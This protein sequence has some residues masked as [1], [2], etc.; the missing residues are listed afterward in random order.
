MSTWLDAAVPYLSALNA[1]EATYGIPHNLLARIAWQESHFRSDIISGAMKSPA[2]AVGIMQ[3]LPQY[4]PG[5]GNSVLADIATAARF[6]ANLYQ[7]FN[8]WQLAVAAYDWGGGNVHQEISS[9]GKPTLDRM[10]LETQNY[11]REVFADVPIA[12]ALVEVA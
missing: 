11:V 7:R 2:G 8:D 9:D 10:P 5:A 3:L 12:G 4:F 6:I 1:A